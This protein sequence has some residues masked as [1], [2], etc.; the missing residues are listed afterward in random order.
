MSVV[1]KE[2][3]SDMSDQQKWDYHEWC[4]FK[5]YGNCD[6]CALQGVKK[7]IQVLDQHATSVV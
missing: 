5:D 7:P 4:W 3:A 2:E 1:S 6:H